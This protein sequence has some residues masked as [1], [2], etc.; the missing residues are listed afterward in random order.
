MMREQ[1]RGL[2]PRLGVPHRE[3]FLVPEKPPPRSKIMKES[4]TK[5]KAPDPANIPANNSIY[6]L[7]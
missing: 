7:A 1:L 5:P 6:I 2:D 3:T 4:K